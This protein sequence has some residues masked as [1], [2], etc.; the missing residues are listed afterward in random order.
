MGYAVM[1]YI[2]LTCAPTPDKAAEA[3]RRLSK[4]PAPNYVGIGPAGDGLPLHKLFKD[5]TAP[6][7]FSCTEALERYL[8]GVCPCLYL[9]IPN[10]LTFCQ[11]LMYETLAI[12]P[13]SST[14][15]HQP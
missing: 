14:C 13:A 3:L 5:F 4:V 7:S 15:Q 2:N 10:P 1:E 11:A 6:L 8:N 12:G 9:S